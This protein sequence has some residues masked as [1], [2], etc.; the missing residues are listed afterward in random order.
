MIEKEVTITLE[1][2]IHA[3]PAAEL[4]KSLNRFKCHVTLYDKGKEYNAKSILS[5]M[6]AAI[7]K[8]QTIRVVI[9]GVDEEETWLFLEQYL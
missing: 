8:G 3:R 4:V 7:K 1:H 5:M 2:G 9:D 6:S